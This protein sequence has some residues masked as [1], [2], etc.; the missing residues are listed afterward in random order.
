MCAPQI[1]QTAEILY[2][3]TQ[4]KQTIRFGTSLWT[5]LIFDKDFS[6]SSRTV[7]ST[8][9]SRQNAIALAWRPAG[10][11]AMKSKFSA[12]LLLLAIGAALVLAPTTRAGADQLITFDD[13]NTGPNG[14]LFPI[15]SPYAGLN[16]NNF[17]VISPATS[18]QCFAQCGYYFGIISSPNVAFNILGN[19]ASFSSS[20]PFTLNSFYLTADENDGLNVS[21]TGLLNGVVADTA[22]FTVDSTSP[23]L[24]IFN[25]ANINEVDFSASGGTA[26]GWILPIP[27]FPNGF[28]IPSGTHFALD[29]VSI[30]T[31]PGPIAGAGLPG[32][33]FASGGLLAWWR[34]KRKDA[35]QRRSVRLAADSLIAL[36]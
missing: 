5:P 17:G 18:N 14:D 33:I 22:T 25:W 36:P 8:F 24:A 19:P 15:S 29:N 16:W 7:V 27:G 9:P 2:T 31:V 28:P 23:T 13:I 10:G 6:S 3:A 11:H 26:H 4:I 21:V 12:T 20:I 35:R 30:S 34:G 1:I 32:L